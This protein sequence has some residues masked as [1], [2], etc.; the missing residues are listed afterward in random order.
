MHHLGTILVA[1]SAIAISLNLSREKDATIEFILCLVWGKSC[2]VATVSIL[3]LQP[4]KPLLYFPPKKTRP[5]NTVLSQTNNPN[6]GAFDIVCEL[7]PHI[8]IILY[9]LYPTRHLF[10]SRLFLFAF[11]TTLFGTISETL[12]IFYLFGSLWSQWQ[13]AFKIVTPVLHCAFS[14]T[15]L[16]GTHIF[17]RMWQKQRKLLL[18]GGIGGGLEAGEGETEGELELK[19]TVEGEEGSSGKLAEVR[20]Q[21]VALLFEGSGRDRKKSC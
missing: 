16:H 1:Q 18:L 2:P 13:L 15:Q 20:R 14:A 12:V 9:R 21:S 5:T 11:G 4:S 19:V 6:P 10:L 8:A 3:C 17:Y 7:C